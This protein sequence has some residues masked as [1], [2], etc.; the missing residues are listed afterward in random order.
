MLRIPAFSPIRCSFLPKS[1]KHNHPHRAGFGLW[2]AP[3]HTLKRRKISQVR[4]RS[5]RPLVRYCLPLFLLL[6]LGLPLVAG[7]NRPQPQTTQVQLPDQESLRE[8][9]DRAIEFTKNNRHLS[10]GD[11]AAWQIVHGALA[12]GPEFEIY[13]DG[14]LTPAI[15]YLLKGGKLRGWDLRKGDRGVVAVL[16]PGSKM[17]Q[18]HPDQWLGYLSQAGLTLDD[19]VTVASGE[20]FTVHDMLTQAQWDMYD[21]MEGTWTLMACSTYL[22]IDAKWTAKDGEEWDIA[23][24]A[25]MEAGQDLFDSACGGT[26]RMY[27]LAIARNK[28]LESGG[29][30]TGD[31]NGAWEIVDKKIKDTAAAAR[32]FQQPDGSFSSNYFS[33]A[34]RSAEIGD[35]ISTT[36]HVLEFLT[37]A[38]DDQQLREPWVTR[39][40]LHLLQCLEMTQKHDLECGSLYHAIHGLI[41]YRDRIYGQPTPT[42]EDAPPVAAN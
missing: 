28:F 20:V 42:L 24:L 29:K 11:Q 25:K 30:L 26:H 1:L 18:G 3:T 27:A 34:A 14:K 17:G 5:A 40:V 10:V 21:G 32:E 35:R 31:P 38:L 12:Y 15:D 7:C 2:P 22:P 41:I 37:V 4:Y 13:V 33:R 6:A 9:I 16:E 8:R 19:K 36:G 39:A 23:R